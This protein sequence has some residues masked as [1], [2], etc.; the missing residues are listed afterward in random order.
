MRRGLC[1]ALWLLTLGASGHRWKPI[2]RNVWK[3]VSLAHLHT[4]AGYDCVCERCGAE[5]R[6]ADGSA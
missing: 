3:S 5:W 1:W 6:D 4:W 2:R